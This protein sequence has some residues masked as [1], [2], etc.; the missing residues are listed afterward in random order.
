MLG[1]TS[2]VTQIKQKAYW[3]SLVLI[4]AARR[5]P[6]AQWYDSFAH[7]YDAAERRYHPFRL[8]ARRQLRLKQGQTVL[9]VACG[10][11]V[12]EQFLVA[13]NPT[14]KIVGVDISEKMLSVALA[15]HEPYPNVS[16]KQARA[17][18]LPFEDERFDLVVC[19]NSFHYFDN[20]KACLQEK[21]RVLKPKG[22]MLIVDW[23][24]DYLMCRIWDLFLRCFDPAYHRCYRQ[25]ELHCFLEDAGLRVLSEQKFLLPRGWGMMIAEAVK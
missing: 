12:L 14:Q 19:A 25:Q 11:G 21:A 15:K 1:R 22:R 24:K 7:I 18:E 4:G 17:S 9:D 16:F 20:P 6:T 10:T 3:A 8:K 13:Q 2:I 23:C 5:L